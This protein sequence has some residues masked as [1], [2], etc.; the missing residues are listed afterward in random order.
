MVKYSN[1]GG[2]PLPLAVFLAT[3]HYDHEEHT[4]SATALIK[5]VRQLILA[6]RVPSQNSVVDLANL[7][8]ARLGTAI[9]DGIERAWHENYAQAMADL[10]YPQ[11]VIDRIRINPDDKDLE[12]NP[13][14]IPV[15]MEQRM[16]REIMGQ[17]ISGKPDF[18]AEGRVEDYKSTSVYVYQN[19]SKA[20]DYVLQGSILRWLDPK[21]ITQDQMRIH[22][23]LM[24]WNAAQARA[25][26]DY[27]Q[28]RIIPKEY[29][30]LNLGDTEA[31]IRNKLTLYYRFKDA[32][33][34]EIPLCT[35]KELWRRPPQ[36]KYY[37][38]PAK[39]AR[40]TKNFDNKHE[41]YARLS[42]DGNVGVVE[43]KG[44]EVMACKYCPAFSVCSQKDALIAD[45]S[46]VL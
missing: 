7:V 10:G 18:I 16:Y 46:L 25:S 30:L 28:Q 23:I 45:G 5:P 31:F 42:A 33:E 24:D 15:Y 14:I 11:R 35:D 2:I 13:D 26:R 44:G 32:P 27:P 8:S 20:E 41:A 40:S 38:N 9:H 36:W 29:Q 37:K 6:D 3:D 17:T 1:Q 19:Q 12:A 21:K 34:P 39:R 22:N 4:I 43:E